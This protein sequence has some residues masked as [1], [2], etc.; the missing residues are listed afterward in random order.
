M[1]LT[2]SHAH[3]LKMDQA[4]F[5]TADA[6]AFLG[7]TNATVSKILGRLSSAGHIVRLKRGLWGLPGKTTPLQVAHRMTAPFPAYV[8][9]QSALFHHGMVSQIPEV[10]YVAS[11][12]RTQRLSTPFCTFSIHHLQPAFFF[13]YATQDDGITR[14][15]LPEKALIDLLYLSAAR[16]GLFRAIPELEIPKSFSVRRARGMV[17]RIPSERQKGYVLRLFDELISRTTV[18]GMPCVS[19]G[20]SAPTP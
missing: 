15:A 19:Y 17:R 7:L 16:S 2:D 13:G 10:I 8:S 5:T 20:I 12:A 18:P 1:R 9:L 14:M 11:L 3:L 4:V 6:A